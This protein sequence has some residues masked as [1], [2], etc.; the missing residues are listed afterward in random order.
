ML[1]NVLGLT[2][3]DFLNNVTLKT[4]NNDMF[5]SYMPVSHLR[6]SRTK[7]MVFIN[8]NLSLRHEE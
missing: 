6:N 1:S 7:H 2:I 5:V 3:D 4:V 8:I